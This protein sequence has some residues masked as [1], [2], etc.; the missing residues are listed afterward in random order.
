[1][2]GYINLNYF[3][4]YLNRTYRNMIS[5]IIPIKCNNQYHTVLADLV[6]H[7]AQQKNK[8]FSKRNLWLNCEIIRT[9]LWNCEIIRSKRNKRPLKC[10]WWYTQSLFD[11]HGLSSGVHQ[12][13]YLISKAKRHEPSPLPDCSCI[14]NLEKLFWYIFQEKNFKFRQNHWWAHEAQLYS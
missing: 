2:A 13:N 7:H 5:F 6:N 1:M 11:K 12:C 3:L 4:T 9:K 8:S 10:L 14:F